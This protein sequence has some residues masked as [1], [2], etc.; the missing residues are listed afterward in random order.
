MVGLALWT[1]IP[2]TTKTFSGA[3][4]HSGETA[5]SSAEGR[6][7]VAQWTALFCILKGVNITNNAYLKFISGKQNR[8]I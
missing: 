7:G 8:A 1:T 3:K 2:P 5:F 4:E 6:V